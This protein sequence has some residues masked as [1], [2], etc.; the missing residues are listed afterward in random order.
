MPYG[1]T[2]RP[3]FPRNNSHHTT[4]QEVWC[5][6]FP[7]HTSFKV[8]WCELFFTPHYFKESVVWKLFH[9]TPEVADTKS[10]T[11]LKAIALF[12]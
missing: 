7:H 1:G 6:N 12:T 3:T 11:R 2:Q 4:L 9:T 5:G 10:K 8:V